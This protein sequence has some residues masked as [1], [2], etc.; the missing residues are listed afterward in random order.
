[1]L[2]TGNQVY[3]KTTAA[4]GELIWRC[5]GTHPYLVTAKPPIKCWVV[6][7]SWPQSLAI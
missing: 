4:L 1:M 7:A 6:C 3:G 2:R 5:L